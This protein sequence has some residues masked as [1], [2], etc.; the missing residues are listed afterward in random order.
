MAGRIIKVYYGISFA[1]GLAMSFF[2]ATYVLFLRDAGLSLLEINLVNCFFMASCFLLEFPT[3]LLADNV[4]RKFSVVISFCLYGIG[5][6]VYYFSASFWMFVLAEIIIAFG[7]TFY[8]GAFDAWLVDAVNH[9][10]K[11]FDLRGVFRRSHVF[12]QSG[13][14]IGV[15][16]GAYAG[17][18]NL[19]LP[20]LL[21]S[22]GF[23][24]VG[25]IAYTT[26]RE[27]GFHKPEKR[28]DI[29]LAIRESVIYGVKNK[30]LFFIIITG[31]IFFFAIAPLNMY[32]QLVFENLGVSVPGLGWIHDATVIS[33][34]IGSIAVKHVSN[35]FESEKKEL[36][37]I[38]FILALSIVLASQSSLLVIV[39]FGYMAHEVARGGFK[40]VR[41]HYINEKIPSS[42]R[43]T[44]L[45]FDSMISKL[46]MFAG[47]LTS[48]LV[49]NNFNPQI[50]WLVSGVAVLV[51]LP[52]LTMFKNGE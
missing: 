40:P 2:F 46:G 10:E 38:L 12:C 45:S 29:R 8:S 48:G 50:S 21:S 13:V 1:N 43:A 34:I 19:A 32:S 11:G 52:L 9:H 37:F 7:S 27:D 3:G 42:K 14:L 16:V 44:L 4:S 51:I 25:A 23:F 36:M 39:L 47:L 6:L 28:V 26:I 41:L 31:F 5:M 49:A 20:W 33:M 30:S 35:Y 18:N 15:L 17:E 22:I 24:V